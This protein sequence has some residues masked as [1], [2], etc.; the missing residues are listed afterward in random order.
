MDVELPPDFREFLRFLDAERVEYLLIGGYAVAFHGYPRTTEDLD[1]W[2]ASNPE[3]A[4]RVV[5][6]IREFG[7][8]LP[9][10]S[11]DMFIKPDNIVRMGVPPLRID[12][13]TTISGVEFAQ[14]YQ[15]RIT[16]VID[17]TPVTLINLDHLKQNK[18]ASGR[19]R[20]LDDLEHLP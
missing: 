8:D 2:V 18:K 13:A 19:H 5:R 12:L 7:F 16:E 3:N 9:E 11:T 6:A 17:G 20:D 10:L 14:C 4:R 15:A 1:I